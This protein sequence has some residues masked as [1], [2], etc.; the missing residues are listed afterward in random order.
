MLWQLA[1]GDECAVDA[2]RGCGCRLW[3]QTVEQSGLDGA[4]VGGDP[5]GACTEWG[6]GDHLGTAMACVLALL[7]IL[8][9]LVPPRLLP[10]GMHV[11]FRSI[12]RVTQA[13][14]DTKE[15]S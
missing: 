9:V 13:T 8:M 2:V 11:P 15:N 14:L 10:G 6:T 7:I 4:A 5:D 12:L 3:R 1:C